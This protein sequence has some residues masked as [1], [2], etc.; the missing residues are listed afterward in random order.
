MIEVQCIFALFGTGISVYSYETHDPYWYIQ[1]IHERL[2]KSFPTV[3]I[4]FTNV[5]L[6]ARYAANRAASIPGTIGPMDRCVKAL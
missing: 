3:C 5:F 1:F 2:Y 6:L 4:A